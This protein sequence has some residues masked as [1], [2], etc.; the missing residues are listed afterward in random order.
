MSVIFFSIFPYRSIFR[1]F[2]K[3][4]ETKMKLKDDPQSIKDKM[5]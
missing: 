4:I 1:Y 5:K 3:F 2:L